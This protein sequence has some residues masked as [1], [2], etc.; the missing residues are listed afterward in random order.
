MSRKVVKDGSSKLVTN[1]KHFQ[2]WLDKENVGPLVIEVGVTYGCNHDCVHCSFQQFDPYNGVNFID[3][4]SF[5]KFL[6]DFKSMGGIEVYFAGNGEPLLHPNICDFFEYGKKIGLDMTMSTNGE[7]LTPEVSERILPTA[8][9]INFSINGG[10]VH[11]YT[12][13]HK[14]T[15]ESFYKV[16]QNIKDFMAYKKEHNLDIK[17]VMQYIAYSLNKNGIDDIVKLFQDL[18]A[19]QLNLRSAGFKSEYN[20]FEDNKIFNKLEEVQDIEGVVVRWNSDMSVAPWSKCSGINFR[21]NM[22]YK[23]NIYPCSKN[24]YEDCTIGSIEDK[25]FKDIWNSEKKKI[26]FH[27]VENTDDTTKCRTWC[28]CRGDNVYIE[29]FLKDKKES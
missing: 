21:I 9:W 12:T 7:Y 24:Y 10:N 15:E 3:K 17:I 11:D 4:D 20:T 1:P 19:D 2:K 13:V 25:S 16:C 29:N 14:C 5:I 23:G 8:K 28:Q 26:T 6:D 27:R 22:D 18:G